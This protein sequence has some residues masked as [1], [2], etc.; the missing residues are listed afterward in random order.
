MRFQ[1]V[2]NGLGGPTSPSAQI[3]D[4]KVVITSGSAATTVTMFDDGSH[5]DGA[6]GDDVYGTQIPA[7]VLGTLVS[8]TVTATDSIGATTTS[9]S[10]SYTVSTPSSILTVTPA[11][12]LTSSGI[13]GGVPSP[14]SVTYTLSNTGSGT[15]NW[16]TSQSA[17]WL[18]LS[19]SSGS[20]AAGAS[21]TVST[22]IN[23]SANNLIAGSYS[24]TVTFTN[25]SNGNGNTTRSVALTVTSGAGVQPR[26]LHMQ[27]S[28]VVGTNYT[29]QYSPDLA[30]G[31]WIEIG[32][33]TNNGNFSE[34]NPN[35]L[36]LP[37][38]FY[39]VVIP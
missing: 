31:S 18:T 9:G 8:Y 7:Q 36:A 28:G 13:S 30:A 19:T 35:R 25:G 1:F 37:K 4:I 12:G 17:P 6:A 15:L 27:F 3:D 5:N 38:G 21:T 11:A 16:T 24:G 39:R 22:I 14:A 10:S 26:L 33:V 2:G 20:L 23:A 34:T 29:L 32:T